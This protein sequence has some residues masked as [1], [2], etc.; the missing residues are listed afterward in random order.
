VYQTAGQA[1]GDESVT[2]NRPFSVTITPSALI[3]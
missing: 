2:L 1:T 3:G